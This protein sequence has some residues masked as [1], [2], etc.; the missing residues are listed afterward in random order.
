MNT[1]LRWTWRFLLGAGAFVLLLATSGAAYQ[2]ASVRDDLARFPPP[3]KL[4]K[5][6]GVRMHLDCRGTGRPVLLLEAGLMSSSSTWM[7]VH[8][9]LART[10]EVCAYDRIGLGW[11]SA[12][13]APRTAAD[14][15][16]RLHGL[17]QASHL[18]GPFVLVGMSAGGVFVREYHARY[19]EGVVGMVLVDSSHEQQLARLPGAASAADAEPMLTLCKW[20]QPVGVVRVS[21]ALA[22]AVTPQED[23]PAFGPPAPANARAAMRATAERSH[24]CASL[25]QEVRG[26]IAT[27][28]PAPPLRTLGDLPLL[29]LSQD[30]GRPL[31]PAIAADP[32]A[33]A[34]ERAQRTAWITLQDELAHASTRGERHVIA[35][36]GHLIQME[37]P[38]AVIKAITQWMTSLRSAP[39]APT[40][41][42]RRDPT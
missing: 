25:L 5:V 1:P 9:T 15:A 18:Q 13:N 42:A 29:V 39:A 10:T 26:F 22:A 34:Q 6:D 4:V 20:L 11:S 19:P 35:G 16:T 28:Q 12:S 30:P 40:P 2:W 41:N 3:G 21:G 7:R 17:V 32:A 14:V 24:G 8:D 31:D 37:R 38:A 27:L 33:V 36:S 23:D